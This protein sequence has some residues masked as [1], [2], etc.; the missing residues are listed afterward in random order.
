M[1]RLLLGLFG[2]IALFLVG[3][4]AAGPNAGGVLVVHDCGYDLSCE[5]GNIVP[6]SCATVD[7]QLPASAG[8]C[9]RFWKVYAAFPECSSPRLKGLA[10]GAVF[11][12][13]VYVIGSSLP[14]PL[15]FEV[16][17]GGW[18]LTSGGGVG[19]NFVT[20]GTKT[21]LMSEVYWFYGYSYG[22]G[23]WSLAPHPTQPTTFMDD[24]STPQM[25]PIAELGSLGFGVPGS[26]PCP[27]SCGACCLTT[28]QC[29]LVTQPVCTGQGGRFA[30]GP[31]E[32][33]ICEP[34][35]TVETRWGRIKADYR[36]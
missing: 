8:P 23:T 22:V 28:G 32:L 9:A 6:T 25:D 29:V 3:P 20:S 24:A 33:T 15:D 12:N 30:D 35:P 11:A 14:D 27:A 26:T 19:I 13:N 34:V 31:C 7:N 2:L 17:E 10:M 16:P 4:A 5:M 21:T 36:R 18:P 1:N